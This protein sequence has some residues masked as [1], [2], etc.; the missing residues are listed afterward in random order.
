MSSITLVEFLLNRLLSLMEKNISKKILVI[1]DEKLIRMSLSLFLEGKGYH[2]DSASSGEESISKLFR[3]K[4]DLMI[5]DI[6]LPDISG[7]EVIKVAKKVM[8]FVKVIAI[9][10]FEMEPNIQESIKQFEG[11][12]LYKPFTLQKINESVCK[13]LKE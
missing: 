6:K 9:T 7:M 4:Y 5:T 2:V 8:P 3:R 10:A 13:I 12:I 11:E 1:D